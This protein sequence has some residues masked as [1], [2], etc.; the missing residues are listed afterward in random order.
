MSVPPVQSDRKVPLV[1]TDSTAR[2][3]HR[4][5][6]DKMVL[7]VRPALKAWPVPLVPKDCKVMLAPQVPM[8]HRVSQDKMVSMAHLVH[9]ALLDLKAFKVKL[10]P[11]VQSDRRA[12]LVKMVSMVRQV[13]KVLLVPLVPR[14]YKVMSVLPVQLDCRE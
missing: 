8:A 4:A 1:R 11:S 7:T 13:H 2:Q 12:L 10:A 14:A 6:L 9:R 5:L 3:A